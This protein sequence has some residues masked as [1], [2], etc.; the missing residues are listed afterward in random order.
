MLLFKIP[1]VVSHTSLQIVLL[2]L[3]WH[4]NTCSCTNTCILY[5]LHV[6]MTRPLVVH[7]KVCVHIQRSGSICPALFA[8]VCANRSC[9]WKLPG[10][11]GGPAAASCGPGCQCRTERS[12]PERSSQQC[13]ATAPA[14]HPSLLFP[15]VCAS[16]CTV[17][18]EKK[19]K[20]KSMLFSDH[21]RSLQRQQPR[22]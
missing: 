18:T 2:C 10:E 17:G 7:N 16:I 19:C 22:V 5:V 11:P 14:G 12:D 21:S 9:L 6:A 20:N 3:Y 4:T 8:V 13:H 15:D 1:C